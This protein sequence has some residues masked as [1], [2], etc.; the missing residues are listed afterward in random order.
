MEFLKNLFDII[1]NNVPP[2]HKEGHSF[3]F[4]FAAVSLFLG[5]IYD[6]FGWIGLVATLW[7]IYF[8]RDPDRIILEGDHFV[9]SP[10]D[11]VISLI[12]KAKAPAELGMGDD[13]YTRVSIFLN[14]FHYNK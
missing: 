10:G 14:V 8:F 2:I 4:I 13:Q 9:V 5:L 1:K 7:C 11:G 3:V 6:P 12:E